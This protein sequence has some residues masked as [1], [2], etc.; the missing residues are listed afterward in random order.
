V[1]EVVSSQK[2]DS[3]LRKASNPIIIDDEVTKGKKENNLIKDLNQEASH[4]KNSSSQKRRKEPILCGTLGFFMS[5]KK[6]LV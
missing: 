3:S 1:K 5:R 6:N 2:K 4:G